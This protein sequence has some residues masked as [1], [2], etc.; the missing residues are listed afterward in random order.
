MIARYSTGGVRKWVR[1]FSGGGAFDESFADMQRSPAN[2]YLI[3]TG[4]GSR[5][6]SKQDWLTASYRPD[7]TLHWGRWI[8]SY[9]KK[10]DVGIGT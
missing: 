10:I 3:V 8:S 1:F 6:A 7:G 4:F 9:G 2:G 5:K